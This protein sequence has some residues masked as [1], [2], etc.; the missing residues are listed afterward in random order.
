M[1]K[2]PVDGKQHSAPNNTGLPHQTHR[3][4]IFD[5]IGRKVPQN[6]ESGSDG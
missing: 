2:S 5:D 1:R 6:A 3:V 4:E